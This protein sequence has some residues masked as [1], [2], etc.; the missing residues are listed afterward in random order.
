MGKSILS[1]DTMVE[2]LLPI[3]EISVLALKEGNRKKPVYEMH[4]WWARRLGAVVRALLVG[5]I[6]PSESS[7]ERFWD[8]FYSKNNYNLVVCDPF[9]GG[10]TTIV[11]ASKIGAKVIG[12]DIDP[13]ACLI[14]KKEIEKI[15]YK[16]VSK[17]AQKIIE[18]VESK[19]D[20][21]YLTIDEMGLLRPIVYC[22]WVDVVKCPECNHET[23]AHPHYKL[24]ENKT[25]NKKTVF[26]K[27]CYNID[28]INY[29]Q[30]KYNC[31]A[32]ARETVVE[33]GTFK[34]GTL[35]CQNCISKIKVT[36]LE[37]L[38]LHK[39][40]FAIE[41]L[42]EDKRYYKKADNYDKKLYTEAS[43]IF[44]ENV[45]NLIFPKDEIPKDNRSD[46]R[47]I[48]HGYKKYFQLFNHR[49]LYCLSLIYKEV[50]NI[51]DKVVRESLLLAFSDSLA[52]NNMLCSYAFGYRKLTPLFGVH[53]YNV[54]SRSVENNVLGEG[55]GTFPRC[56]DKI[57][58]GFKY[59]E[60]PYEMKYISGQANRVYTGEKISCTVSDNADDLYAGKCNALLINQ[61]S[62]KLTPIKSKYVDII[63]TDPPY[64]D[65]LRYSELADFYY[66]WLKI[67][68]EEKE[69]IRNSSLFADS[70]SPESVSFFRAGL[71]KVFKESSRI[72][73]DDGIMIF[74]YHHRKIDAWQ[75]MG[76][77]LLG[78]GFSIVN[79]FP[80][81]SEGK[82]GFHS[83]EGSIKWDSI[84]VFRKKCNQNQKSYSANLKDSIELWRN[85]IQD[86]NLNMSKA[87]WNSFAMSLAMR[88][89]LNSSRK[90][91]NKLK[92]LLENALLEVQAQ[93][94]FE[95]K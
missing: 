93:F 60:N 84:L 64:Y 26:C 8:K 15:N 90:S 37:G 70:T 4:K 73:K 47:P 49:Q 16:K 52:K 20:K 95:V 85:Y 62:K 59:A 9:M 74:S 24:S 2:N 11:E 1:N 68:W 76:E 57:V 45:D 61:D 6:L 91:K 32:C 17:T 10:G 71:N 67:L 79:V 78:T 38:P 33:S 63:L 3:E 92:K 58:N 13:I 72:L 88:E 25:S 21:F 50:I 77:A 56:V 39:K 18:S 86:K 87:D 30:E 75:C 22:F 40:L 54:V 82:S 65:N 94:Y 23:D 55:R 35:T 83:Y 89:W 81:R 69:D 44:A 43:N 42:K 12:L 46:S 51:N 7:I 41:Y 53:G 27:Y 31:S 14:T 19:I 80:I 29:K 66:H 28:E 5:S 36:G 48:C 34:L